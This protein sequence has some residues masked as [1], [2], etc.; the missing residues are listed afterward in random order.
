VTAIRGP[1]IYD[2]ESQRRNI[3]NLRAGQKVTVPADKHATREE[4]R[5]GYRE[6]DGSE[7]SILVLDLTAFGVDRQVLRQ[8]DMFETILMRDGR[9]RFDRRFPRD[10]RP[11]EEGGE[12]GM[13]PSE[14][15]EDG[16][17]KQFQENYAKVLE[18]LQLAWDVD[19]NKDDDKKVIFLQDTGRLVWLDTDKIKRQLPAP[20]SASAT[21]PAGQLPTELKPGP[22]ELREAPAAPRP[23]VQVPP[24]P[25]AQ[26]IVKPEAPRAELKEAPGVREQMVE[27]VGAPSEARFAALLDKITAA[28]ATGVEHTLDRVLGEAIADL[29]ASVGVTA[30]AGAAGRYIVEYKAGYDKTFIESMLAKLGPNVK[31]V[32]YAN[33]AVGAAEREMLTQLDTANAQLEVPLYADVTSLDA[34]VAKVVQADELTREFGKVTR[35]TQLITGA[36]TESANL[37]AAL[38][39]AAPLSEGEIVVAGDEQVSVANVNTQAIDLMEAVETAIRAE[40]RVLESA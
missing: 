20:V 15:A 16:I 9:T 13:K 31:L 17:E 34:F 33:A 32:I 36:V 8:T 19:V 11:K 6:I 39:S 40:A 18:V 37:K 1:A 7:V 30:K 14:V 12:R 4:E 24:Q 28:D 38:L 22:A 5:H 2:L 27:A 23:E 26:E 25:V 3:E 29:A 35:I 10:T 21:M